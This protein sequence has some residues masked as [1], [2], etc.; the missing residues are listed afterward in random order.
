MGGV[1]EAGR[2]EAEWG[3]EGGVGME[4]IRF[5]AVVVVVGGGVWGE[6]GAIGNGVSTWVGKR[7]KRHDLSASSGRAC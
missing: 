5:N 6:G 1:G 4:R 7:L 3:E 2:G